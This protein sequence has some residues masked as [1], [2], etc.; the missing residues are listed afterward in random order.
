MQLRC[1]AGPPPMSDAPLPSD[2]PKPV[3]RGR[4]RHDAWL[5]WLVPVIAAVAGL[6]LV[7]R[8]YMAAGPTITISFKTA[9]G[10]DESTTTV[11]YKNVVVGKVSAIRLDNEENRVIVTVNLTRDA[12]PFAVADTRFWVERPRLDLGGISGLTTLLSG[13]YIGIDV[14]T[15][16]EPR[17]E[18]EGLETPPPITHTQ[19]GLRLLLSS[20]NLGSLNIGS[21][22]YFHQLPVGRIVGY[23]L[24]PDGSAVTLHAFV[25]A[26]Y[27][28][29]VNAGTRFFNI[30]GVSVELGANG[31]EVSAQSLLSLVAGG[32]AFEPDPG[33]PAQPVEQNSRFLLYPTRTA[34]LPPP[35]GPSALVRM[36]FFQSVRGLSPG[37]PVELN[38]LDIG[39]VIDIALDYDRGQHKVFAEVTAEIFTSRLGQVYD[40]LGRGKG[41]DAAEATLERLMEYGLRAQ[42]RAGNLITGQMYVALELPEKPQRNAT[43]GNGRPL[44]IVTVPGGVDQILNQLAELIQK[45]N[46]MPFHDIGRQLNSTLGSADKLLLRLDTELAPEARRTLGEVRATLGS[47]RGKLESGDGSVVQDAQRTFDEVGRAARSLRCLTDYLQRHPEALLRGKPAGSPPPPSGE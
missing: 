2:L 9:E 3:I 24:D 4:R 21:P 27:D 32:I 28:R 19:Q 30:S 45:L 43:A 42:L 14:G 6:V 12:E 40:K 38:G 36:R 11:K 33:S 13:A 41:L 1:G 31:L 35:D 8:G 17:R 18:F 16:T 46:S 34:A 25:E 47:V 22:I 37:A 15:S 10:L 29:Y 44:E 5:I 23:E 7:V 26:P 20:Y 39:E